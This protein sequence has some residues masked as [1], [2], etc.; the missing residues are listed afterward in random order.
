MLTLGETCLAFISPPGEL[1]IIRF[2]SM[3]KAGYVFVQ[4]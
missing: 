3:D 2:F 4:N 1:T